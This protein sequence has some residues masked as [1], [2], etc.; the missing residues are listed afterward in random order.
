MSFTIKKLSAAET[1]RIAFHGNDRGKFDDLLKA[2][3][4]LAPGEGLVLQ[5]KHS[6]SIAQ[7]LRAKLQK[8]F[9]PGSYHLSHK[10]DG[11]YIKQNPEHYRPLPASTV[12]AVKR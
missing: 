12:K 5:G 1:N 3:E 10:D 2:F 7:G 4:S 6:K 11:I 8:T 9:G